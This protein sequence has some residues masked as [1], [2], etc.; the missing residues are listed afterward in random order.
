MVSRTMQIKQAEKLLRLTLARSVGAQY[1]N[2]PSLQGIRAIVEGEGRQALSVPAAWFGTSAPSANAPACSATANANADADAISAEEAEARF[3]AFHAR[4]ENNPYFLGPGRFVLAGEDRRWSLVRIPFFVFTGGTFGYRYRDR[5]KSGS[6]W[7]EEQRVTF[8]GRDAAMQTCGT[9]QYRHDFVE[10][11]KGDR[12]LAALDGNEDGDRDEDGGSAGD[13]EVTRGV[14][15]DF[16]VRNVERALRDR[17]RERHGDGVRVRVTTGT[18]HGSK[19][20][21]VPAHVVEYTYAEKVDVH[22]ERSKDRF[23]AIVSADGREVASERHVSVRRAAV[24]GGSAAVV[25]MGLASFVGYE[26]VLGWSA[27][28]YGFIGAGSAAAAALSAQ[29]VRSPQRRRRAID[30]A[31][32]DDDGDDDEN[33]DFADAGG[34]N[35]ESAALERQYKSEWARWEDGSVGFDVEP[36]KRKRWAESIWSEHR[37]RKKALRRVLE[38]RAEAKLREAENERRRARLGDSGSPRSRLGAVARDRDWLG[39]YA[40]LE[41]DVRDELPTRAEIKRAFL[42]RVRTLHPDRHHVRRRRAGATKGQAEAEAEEKTD[43]RWLAALE[44]YEFLKDDERRA[45]Y[46]RGERSA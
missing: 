10:M 22:N 3:M 17:L 44:A 12:V 23:Y 38:E 26:S 37:R 29:V 18:P 2:P 21:L 1:P 36:E 42:R 41:L 33:N 32:N 27:F 45:R 31:T 46:D 4:N 25:A 19:R 39:H 8:D 5:Q 20:V 40:A 6:R 11:L 9:F 24:V 43:P 28:D 14:A 15:W 35:D 13:V 16:A 7:S 34:D 30:E